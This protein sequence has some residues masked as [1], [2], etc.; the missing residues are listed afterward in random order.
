MS[1]SKPEFL[2]VQRQDG[3]HQRIIVPRTSADVAAQPDVPAFA[4][5]LIAFAPLVNG[6]R[7]WSNFT[8]VTLVRLQDRYG[9]DFMR[10]VLASLLDDIKSGL[11]ATNPIG[12]LI[13]R[14]RIAADSTS[15]CI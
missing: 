10:R 14:L 4:L 3:T 13:H 6:R 11:R 5:A 8:R 7:M 1:D 12:L 15:L 9:D 2:E